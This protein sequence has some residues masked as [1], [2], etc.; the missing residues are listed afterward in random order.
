MTFTSD[1]LFYIALVSII[2]L[3]M[4]WNHGNVEFMEDEQVIAVSSDNNEIDASIRLGRKEMRD[5]DDD[6][7]ISPGQAAIAIKNYLSMSS[8]TEYYGDEEAIKI[9]KY[10]DTHGNKLSKR[11]F[12]FMALFNRLTAK[13][14]EKARLRKAM[15]TL[16]NNGQVDDIKVFVEK[17]IEDQQD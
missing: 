9:T 14:P 11:P 15:S 8:N 7:D 6:S 5:S 1:K 12:E 4:L 3:Y 10:I 16:L 13:N 17:V 2:V